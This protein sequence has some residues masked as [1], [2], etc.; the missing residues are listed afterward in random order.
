MPALAVDALQRRRLVPVA[1]AGLADQQ[2]DPVGQP[3]EPGVE[4]ARYP[5]P[6][7]LGDARG[8]PGAVIWAVGAEQHDLGSVLY[9]S[10]RPWLV[11]LLEWPPVVAGAIGLLLGLKPPVAVAVASEPDERPVSVMPRA[12]FQAVGVP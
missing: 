1:V 11:V 3:R 12:V 7:S 9:P 10:Q 4:V 8:R 2:L 5:V 6:A